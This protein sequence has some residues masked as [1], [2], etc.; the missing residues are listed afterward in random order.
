MNYKELNALISLL[1]D[2][3]KEIFDS[4]KSRLVELGVEV[5]PELESAWESNYD[6]L[7]QERTENIINEIHF[8]DIVRSLKKWIQISEN[9]ILLDV[10]IILITSKLLGLF[11]I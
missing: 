9:Y 6:S 7:I 3:D 4:V 11:G 1:E 2:P 5:L 10:E 8:R